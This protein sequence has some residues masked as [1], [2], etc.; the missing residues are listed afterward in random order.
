[1]KKLL[2]SLFLIYSTTSYAAEPTDNPDEYRDCIQYTIEEATQNTT[3]EN[4]I[5][6]F[7][8]SDK[9]TRAFHTN[10]D[11]K[12]V[13][14]EEITPPE[15]NNNSNDYPEGVQCGHSGGSC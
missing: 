7:T 5:A 8:F 12:K 9:T 2:L 3:P 15:N 14:E 6:T 4:N 10:A 11:C 1:M 13:E